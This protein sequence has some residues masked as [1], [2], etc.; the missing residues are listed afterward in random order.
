MATQAIQRKRSKTVG[1][2]GSKIISC[3]FM[4]SQNRGGITI[5]RVKGRFREKVLATVGEWVLKF[6]SGLLEV[7]REEKKVFLNL[8]TFDEEV[9]AVPAKRNENLGKLIK[10]KEN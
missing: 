6:M 4:L 2:E 9:R 1:E 7:G 10:I 8:E 5:T 3:L